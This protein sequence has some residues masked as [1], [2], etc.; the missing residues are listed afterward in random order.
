VLAQLSPAEGD[1]FRAF[2]R[3]LQ[4]KSMHVATRV[5]LETTGFIEGSK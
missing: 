1:E 4:T 3:T 5:L 2:A